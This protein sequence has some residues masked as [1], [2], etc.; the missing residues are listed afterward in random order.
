MMAARRTRAQLRAL[1]RA[2]PSLRIVPAHDARA[3]SELLV[4]GFS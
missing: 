1:R 3:L 4:P 2:N